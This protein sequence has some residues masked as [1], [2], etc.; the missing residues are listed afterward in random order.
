MPTYRPE[1]TGWRTTPRGCPGVG[2]QRSH[3]TMVG[4][5]E[6]P[7]DGAR[8]LG[9]PTPAPAGVV[10]VLCGGGPFLSS[11]P[12]ISS[13]LEA[14]FPSAPRCAPS[15]LCLC[16]GVGQEAVCA[17]LSPGV[18]GGWDAAFGLGL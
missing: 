3:W 17:C 18:G 7:P 4:V 5:P 13:Y 14:G 16:R 1:V 10:K 8:C 2:P 12:A 11:E 9:G 15:H 6:V